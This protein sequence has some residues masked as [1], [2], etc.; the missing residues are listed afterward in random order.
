MHC[1][2]DG[3]SPMIGLLYEDGSKSCEH[4]T[5]SGVHRALQCFSRFWGTRPARCL[6]LRSAHP[7]LD[8]PAASSPAN[9][10]CGG[11]R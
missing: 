11:W 9:N 3:V 8:H 10:G 1:A 5:T 6:S 2:L 4:G 7:M